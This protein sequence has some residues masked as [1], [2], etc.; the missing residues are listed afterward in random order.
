MYGVS[1]S[2]C[3]NVYASYRLLFVSWRVIFNVSCMIYI[4]H[5]RMNLRSPTAEH[6]KMNGHMNDQSLQMESPNTDIPLVSD[7]SIIIPMSRMD[8]L[9]QAFLT[10]IRRPVIW[11]GLVV[12]VIGGFLNG[13][14][15]DTL[16]HIVNCRVSCHVSILRYQDMS[17]RYMM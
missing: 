11:A 13:K 1:S 15:I 3:M 7:S 14:L 9:K 2:L 10:W 4:M 16:I 5:H 17:C 6:S 8:T 12:G